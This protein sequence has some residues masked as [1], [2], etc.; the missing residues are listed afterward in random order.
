MKISLPARENWNS[1]TAVELSVFV[2]LIAKLL[3]GWSQ[4]E[5]SVGNGLS[6][7]KFPAAAPCVHFSLIH[8]TK[9]FVLLL[10]FRSPRILSWR[11]LTG[12]SGAPTQ[13]GLPLAFRSG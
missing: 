3:L 7:Q 13:V 2:S 10:I 12:S 11:V 1:F 9:T 6:P 8:R 4:S 5:L